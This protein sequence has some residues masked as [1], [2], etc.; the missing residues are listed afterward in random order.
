MNPNITLYLTTVMWQGY[1][2]K[3]ASPN[4]LKIGAQVLGCFLENKSADYMPKK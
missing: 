3:K 1:S 2:L 4:I